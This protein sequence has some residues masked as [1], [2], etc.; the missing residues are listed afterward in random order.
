MAR[1][2]ILNRQGRRYA[3]AAP[4]GSAKSTIVSY[5]LVLHD[6][7][8]ENEKYILLISATQRQAEQRLKLIRQTLEKNK[9]L[10]CIFHQRIKDYDI[11]STKSVLL[12]GPA[13]IEAFGAGCEMRGI[14]HDSWR[15]TK[16]I[17]DDA[18]TSAAA[19]SAKRREDLKVWFSDII[20]NLGHPYTHILAV[21]TIL[22]RESLLSNLLER[23]E[24]QGMRLKSIQKFADDSKLWQQWRELA[25][26]L[27]DDERRETARKFYHMH[28]EEMSR[29][30]VVNWP[31]AEDYEMLQFQLL[32]QG[33]RAFFQEKQ[34]EPLGRD[35]SL[36][37]PN[38]AKLFRETKEGYA[39]RP[40][41]NGMGTEEKP[42]VY[43]REDLLIVAHLDSALGK[44]GKQKGDFAAIAV[45]GLAEDG[46]ILLLDLWSK[47]A[48]P[49]EQIRVLW[50]LHELYEFEVAGIEGTGFQELLSVPLEQEEKERQKIHP[51]VTLKTKTIKPRLKKELR[52]ARL[53]PLLSGKRL[54]LN[55]NLPE[56]FWRELSDFPQ[57]KHDDALDATDAAVQLG[58]A[59]ITDSKKDKIE[60]TNIPKKRKWN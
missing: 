34:N 30:A 47:R 3:L 44:S 11:R 14:S 31:E 39:L 21:G 43:K 4:R 42:R 49:T 25:T 59:T 33:R 5:L 16:I 58:L 29:G 51:G 2:T 55:E 7:L 18:E 1:N 52:I 36:F 23:S 40:N 48:R 28:Q 46:Q 20:E 9:V 22:H 45:V 32:T 57:T 54:A 35:D 19:E 8:Y 12:F 38:E 56:E 37:R 60:I 41:E 27:Q 50:D 6:I 26:N 13:R 15:P 10:R 53:E 17:L 24:F